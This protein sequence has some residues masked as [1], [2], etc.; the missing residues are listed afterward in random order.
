MHHQPGVPKA[1]VLIWSGDKFRLCRGFTTVCS[2]SG[3]GGGVVSVMVV[4]NTIV[5]GK[6][7]KVLTYHSRNEQ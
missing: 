2:V 7:E 4:E 3:E 5:I 1:L 6:Q